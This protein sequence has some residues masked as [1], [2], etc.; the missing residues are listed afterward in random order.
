MEN[1]ISALFNAL[2]DDEGGEIISYGAVKNLSE[3]QLRRLV[4]LSYIFP[5]RFS[6]ALKAIDANEC[7]HYTDDIRDLWSIGKFVPSLQLWT[8]PCNDFLNLVERNVVG[9]WRRA[10]CHL[11]AAYMLSSNFNFLPEVPC[12]A[13]KTEELAMLAL[14]GPK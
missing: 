3:S 5:G 13:L 2:H 12:V 7:R 10:C 14:E 6:I 11:L 9:K 8:C 4:A 1:A